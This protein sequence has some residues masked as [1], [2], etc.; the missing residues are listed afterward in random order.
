MQRIIQ[1]TLLTT[2]KVPSTSKVTIITADDLL[3]TA[4]EKPKVFGEEWVM[5]VETLLARA[6]PT[7]NSTT[8]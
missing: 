1:T 8:E 4:Q 3:Q 5:T 7:T 2:N 6:N